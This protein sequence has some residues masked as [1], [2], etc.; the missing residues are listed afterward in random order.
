M[1]RASSGLLMD[2]YGVLAES[3][4][5]GLL[6][7][8]DRYGLPSGALIG[9][10]T[11]AANPR[12]TAW[13][14]IQSGSVTPEE[15]LSSILDRVEIDHGVRVPSAEIISLFE[16]LRVDSALLQLCCGFRERHGVRIGLVSN[17]F[18]PR[19]GNPALELIE[20]TFDV[21]VCSADVGCQKPER[22][23]YQAAL[24]RL[25]VPVDRV[26]YVDDVV[27][28]VE[29]AAA[30]GMRALQA[31]GPAAAAAV[32]RSEEAWLRGR[33]TTGDG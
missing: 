30:M 15:G 13:W 2:L 11:V 17:S 19:G 22:E 31:R 29:V 18:R 33:T 32:L 28:F 26:L 8:D 1:S 23:I 7:L 20:R 24:R 3:P 12:E 14:K 27:E 21:V 25:E 10:A 6:S 5:A 16:G 9:A 4:T